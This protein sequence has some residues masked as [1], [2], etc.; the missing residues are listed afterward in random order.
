MKKSNPNC[1]APQPTGTPFI[2]LTLRIRPQ[3]GWLLYAPEEGS[4]F[5]PCH[6]CTSSPSY[7]GRMNEGK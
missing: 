6:S 4:L 7:A 2:I 5:L 1:K 3:Y